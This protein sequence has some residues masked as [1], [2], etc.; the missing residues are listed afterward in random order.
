MPVIDVGRAPDCV[1]FPEGNDFPIP[2]SGQ[3]DT[4]G[5]D[6]MLPRGVEMPC[7][8]GAGLKGD[9]CPGVVGGFVGGEQHLDLNVTGK[10]F[11]RP[12]ETLLRPG[13]IYHLR[14]RALFPGLI[15]TGIHNGYEEH[16]KGH[17]HEY[18]YHCFSPCKC[19]D[20]LMFHY[21]TLLKIFPV[22][23]DGV[24]ESRLQEV[25]LLKETRHIL[26][27][28][29][30][31]DPGLC[32]VDQGH[33]IGYLGGRKFRCDANNYLMTSVTMPFECE[34]YAN[35]EEPSHGLRI[36]IDPGQLH[37]RIGRIDWP[38]VM[39]MIGEKVLP[40]GIGPAV[41]DK[42]MV[43]TTT[44][45]VKCLQSEAESQILGPGP[46]REILYR[47][48]CGTAAPV[49]YA[50]TVHSCAFSQVAPAL[51]VL[52]NDY[53]A[54]LDV[55]QSASAARM[56]AS[57]FL[58]A[59]KEITSDFPMQYLKKVRL[60]KTRYLIVQE[61]IKAYIAADK[62]GYE[63]PSRFS[64]KFKRCFRQRPAEMMRELRVASSGISKAEI[65]YCESAWRFI[66]SKQW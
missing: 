44:R 17:Y 9:I 7:G 34:T 43:V 19:N 20:Y 41:M 8:S 48:L 25:F 2:R 11:F 45:L 22:I 30:V 39:G 46:M 32:I 52:Q 31:C 57:A 49:L 55:E 58:R 10:K 53:S 61:N 13:L 62:V 29:K 56:N 50:L 6:H 47:A 65:V 59:F 42:E 12:F 3:A 63:S 5:D 54:K 23:D 28:P 1:T 36:Y 27:R 26:R 14:I 18:M 64:R 24:Y 4:V 35:S 40:C 16:R 33:K 60:T 38:A 37:D 21:W 51:K 15:G 66:K